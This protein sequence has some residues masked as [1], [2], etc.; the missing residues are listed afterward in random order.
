[1]RPIMLP[2]PGKNPTPK[3]RAVSTDIPCSWIIGC[4]GFTSF[5][6]NA[7]DLF[8]PAPGSGSGSLDFR[9]LFIAGG[10]EGFEAAFP[11]APAG[12]ISSSRFAAVYVEQFSMTET[13]S[14]TLPPARCPFF[15]HESEWQY[16]TDFASFTK[17]VFLLPDVCVGRGHMP[18]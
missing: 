5:N 7:R 12:N 2:L 11:P 4:D 18:L 8:R 1:M 13:K 14:I 16:H 17:N 15:L 9:P 10:S 3:N 6:A